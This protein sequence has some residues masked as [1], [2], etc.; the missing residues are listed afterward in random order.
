MKIRYLGHSSFLLTSAG[1][2]KIVTDPYGEVGLSMPT[3][4]AD[5]VT[6]SHSHYDHCNVRAVETSL[7][8][9]RAGEYSC[10]DFSIVSTPCWHDDAHGRKRGG[11]LIFRF[12]ADGVTVVHLGDVG[13]PFSA[14]LAET[15]GNPDVLL[16][17]VG[18]RYTIDGDEAA[19]YVKKIAPAIAIP[20]HYFVP[21]LT[22]DIAGPE[23]FL[24]NFK[25]VASVA[26]ELDLRPRQ[27]RKTQILFMERTTV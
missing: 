16:L 17:P 21:G 10:G 4:S 11:N 9:D 27:D 6:V 26:G 25:E 2:T 8:F 19:R 22:V 1:G 5:A 23:R 12:C 24:K 3:T 14:E 13:E 18:G 20:M 15:I 7:V